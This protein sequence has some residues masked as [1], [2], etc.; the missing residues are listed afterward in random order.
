MKR[1]E[2]L[3][4]GG[5]ASFSAMLPAPGWAQTP[6]YYPADYA[7]LIEAAKQE[8]D[9]LVYSNL[10]IDIWP[11]LTK[12]VQAV[13]P[14]LNVQPVD[15]GSGEGIERYLME[16][17]S[18][19]RT[20][21]LIVTTAPD[22]WI[23]MLERG[24]IEPYASPEADK[25]PAWS[26][27]E[28]G[29]YNVSLDPVMMLWNK[30]LLKEELWPTS[31]AD[32]VAKVTANPDVFS[33]KLGTMSPLL[34]QFGYSAYFA[35]VKKHGDKAWQWFDAICPHTLGERT[36]GPMLEKVTTGEYM[37]AYNLSAATALRGLGK[38]EPLL[39]WS[40]I[41]DGTP[42]LTRGAA[43]TRSATNK[44]SARLLLDFF[45]SKRGQVALAGGGRVPARPDITPE[46]INGGYTYSTLSDKLGADNLLLVEYDPS[47]VAQYNDLM[48][49]FRKAFGQA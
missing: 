21:D 13:Y 48:G 9:L 4:S 20:C 47:L 6:D 11:N 41:T 23:N 43:I 29:L 46:D 36:A 32:L 3:L 12:A 38:R 49:R 17:G 35:M 7:K 24:E 19:S 14:W 31:F 34:S 27:K 45:L 15:L 28:P 26:K 30:Q 44:N 16:R 10:N 2:F 39:A 40:F 42:V 33:R 18:G 22:A 8:P 25:Y 5:A 37:L 1:R